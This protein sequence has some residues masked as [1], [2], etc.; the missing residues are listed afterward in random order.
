MLSQRFILNDCTSGVFGAGPLELCV[1]CVPPPPGICSTAGPLPPL[2]PASAAANAAAAASA[3]APAKSRVLTA[4]E[5]ANRVSPWGEVGYCIVLAPKIPLSLVAHAIFR[6]LSEHRLQVV[7]V[8][9][10]RG[11][12]VDLG[13]IRGV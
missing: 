6:G 12:R 8:A 5:I 7:A 2:Q 3:R 10:A 11:H 4:Q 1:C 13:A 9:E